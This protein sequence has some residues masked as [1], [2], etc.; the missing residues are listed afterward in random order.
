MHYMMNMRKKTLRFIL[1]FLLLHILLAE[2]KAQ[3][4]FGS[5]ESNTILNTKFET[6]GNGLCQLEK[7]L[8][9]TRDSYAEFGQSVWADY[10]IKFSARTPSTEK[11]VQI[12][13]GFRAYNRD[14]RYVLGFRGGNQNSL[15]FAR[16]GYMGADEF[17]ALRMLDF[18]PSTG[19]WY[20]FRIRVRGNRFQ[21]FLNNETLPRIDVKDK[22]NNLAPSGKITLGGGWI[23]TEYKDLSVSKPSA[24]PLSEAVKEYTVI[25]SAT[26]KEKKRVTE[27][28]SYQAL[29]VKHLAAGR[30]AI[31]LDGKWLFMP[32]YQL[33]EPDIATSPAVSDDDWHVM[34]VPS[35]WNPIRIW[36]HGEAFGNASKGTSDTYFRME[37]ARCEGYTFDYKKTSFAWYRQWIEL[38]DNITEKNTELVFDA[39]SKVAEVWINGVKAGDHIGMFG[40]MRVEGRSLFKPGKNLV[41]VKVVRDYVKDIKDAGKIIDVAVSVEVTNKML[42]DLAHG[43]YNG[44]PAG[45]WQPVSLII[46]DAL[47]LQDVFIKPHLTGAQFDITLKNNN[48]KATTFYISTAIKDKKTGAILTSNKSLINTAIKAG[49]EKIFT[50]SIDELKPK[51]WSPQSPNLYDFTFSVIADNKEL[52]VTTITSGFRTFESRDGYLWLNGKRY[53][54]RGGN[55]TPFALAPNSKELADSFFQVMKRGNIDITRTHTSPWNELWM[56]A[57][58]SNGIGVSFEGSWP[59]LFLSSSMPDAKLV[60]LWADEFMALLKKFRNHPSLLLWTVNNEM[61]FYDNDPDTERAKVKMKIIS[62]VVK[63][64][65]KVDSTRPIVFDSNYKRKKKRFGEAFYTDIDD[66]DIDDIHAYIN[67]YDHSLFRQ[68]NGEFQKEN[69]NEGRPLISQE[70]SSGYPN[71]E[72]GHA[73]RFYTIVHQNPQSLIG[74][75]AYENADPANF[76]EV[77]SFITGEQAEAFRRSDDQA[78]GIIHFALLTWFRNVY[79]AKKIEP[80]PTYY[81]MKRALSPV[82]VSAELWGRH[83]YAGDKLPARICVVNDKEDGSDLPASTLSWK[84]VADNG[85][86]ISSGKTGVTIVKHYGR[87][88]ITPDIMIPINLTTGKLNAKLVLELLAKGKAVS[89]NEYKIL[90]AKKQWSGLQSAASKKIVLVDFNNNM[91]PVFDLLNIKTTVATSISAAAGTQADLYVFAGL[92]TAKNCSAQD[93]RQIR[94]IVA[95]GGKLLLLSSESASKAM[96]PEYITGWLT[97]LEADM[98]NPEIPESPVFNDIEPLELRYFNNTRRELPAVCNMS[99]M[100]NRSSNINLLASHIR[101]H[102]YINGEM[103]QRSKFMETIKGFPIVKIKDNG[104]AIISTMLVEKGITDPIAGK[105]LSNMVADLLGLSNK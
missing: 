84:L 71:T 37:T 92:D 81:A 70:M 28:A 16:M 2:V 54:L 27:R 87:E 32:G 19:V 48:T 103:D 1:L 94:S 60:D 77:Q 49:E 31:S 99:L 10:D 42:K 58:D 88:W 24:E 4:D 12:W 52:D 38:P 73:T 7:G 59:W 34:T 43:F 22:N 14:D 62:D 80:Y 85:T 50:Y 89:T 8:L 44:D 101:I 45:I 39:V 63:R 79:D 3:P 72:T 69:K 100:V 51:L 11:Q 61:K 36:L 64:M 97:D 96:Y 26:D 15:Y 35:F 90:L 86:I 41:T 17:L 9:I 25:I 95:K 75:L 21:V 23:K 83:F 53:W 78:S 46:T 68:F 91:K 40:E 18:K 74:N 6:K 57:A 20:H 30:T 82:L 104:E 105:L 65:R 47:K 29:Q 56:N 5:K 13:A 76:L 93:I 98:A 102:G 66:G 67:W 33:G 55:H